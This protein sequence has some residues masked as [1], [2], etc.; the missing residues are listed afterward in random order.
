MGSGT[1][2]DRLYYGGGMTYGPNYLFNYYY[3]YFGTFIIIL[4]FKE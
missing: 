3:Y 4:G 2:M 1:R